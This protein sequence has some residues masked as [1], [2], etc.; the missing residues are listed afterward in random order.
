[1]THF[2]SISVAFLTQ[3]EKSHAVMNCMGYVNTISLFAA[4]VL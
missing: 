1:M 2:G 3:I 4:E